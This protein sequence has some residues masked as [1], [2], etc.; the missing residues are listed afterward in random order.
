MTKFKWDKNKKIY[1]NA[2][3]ANKTIEEVKNLSFQEKQYWF[4]RQI[5]KLRIPWTEGAEWL[6]IDK[7]NILMGS[8]S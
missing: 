4:R 5:Q 8:L 1:I 6:K 3:L 7:S 2:S